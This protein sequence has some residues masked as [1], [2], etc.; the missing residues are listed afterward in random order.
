MVIEGACK[1]RFPNVGWSIPDAWWSGDLWPDLGMVHQNETDHNSTT[2]HPTHPHPPNCLS[3]IHRPLLEEN[4]IYHSNVCQ[5]AENGSLILLGNSNAK[6]GYFASFWDTLTKKLK[7]LTNNFYSI[8]SHTSC[9]LQ[10]TRITWI[11]QVLSP[12]QSLFHGVVMF[13]AYVLYCIPNVHHHVSEERYCEYQG[14]YS[15]L[16]TW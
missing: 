3:P 14:R 15:G 7:K 4:L 10:H 11:A 13:Q 9:A 1:R 8:C 6:F 12:L 2:H 5:K 16:K